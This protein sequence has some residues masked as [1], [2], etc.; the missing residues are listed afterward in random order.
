MWQQPKPTISMQAQ[1]EYNV[2][3]VSN[4]LNTLDRLNSMHI[5]VTAHL[6]AALE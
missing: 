6:T 5:N 1:S 4:L 2:Q 3:G